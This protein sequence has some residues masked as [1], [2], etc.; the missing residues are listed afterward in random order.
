MKRLLMLSVLSL[1]L[2]F[3]GAA[4]ATGTT[5][6]LNISATIASVCSVTTTPVSFGTIVAGVG[7]FNANGDV[8]VNCSPGVPYNIALDS[9]QNYVAGAYRSIKDGG[10]NYVAYWL[11]K[12]AALTSEWGDSD[13]A[14]TYLQGTSLAD[15][16][17]GTDQTHVVYGLLPV[18]GTEAV[19]AYSDVV[20]VSVYY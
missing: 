11:Y 10:V 5:S 12:D 2:A 17:T 4:H 1:G 13:R 9:G 8:S 18:Y 19:G 16:G 15:T 3:A 14:S 6:Q 7:N 20:N